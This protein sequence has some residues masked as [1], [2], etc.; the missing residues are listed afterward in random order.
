MDLLLTETPEGS[1][2]D[3]G[4]SLREIGARVINAENICPTES[5]N[6]RTISE[7]AGGKDKLSQ[8]VRLLP[9]GRPFLW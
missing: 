8:V 6:G 3:I 4:Q 9:Q 1:I 7:V 5:L 2:A